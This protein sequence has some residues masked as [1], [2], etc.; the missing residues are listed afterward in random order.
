MNFLDILIRIAGLKNPTES[1]LTKVNIFETNLIYRLVL[2]FNKGITDKYSSF[3]T[4]AGVLTQ[5]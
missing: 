3:Q 4:K 2:V 1:I 5:V